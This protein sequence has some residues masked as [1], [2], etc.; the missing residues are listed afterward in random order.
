MNEKAN[1]K[2][3]QLKYKNSYKSIITKQARA[4]KISLKK[5]VELLTQTRDELKRPFEIAN[6]LPFRFRILN[7]SLVFSVFEGRKYEK[8]EVLKDVSRA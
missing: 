3:R 5:A 4:D 6:N 8:G 2:H 1:S 7:S